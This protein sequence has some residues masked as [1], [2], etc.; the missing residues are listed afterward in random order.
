VMSSWKGWGEGLRASPVPSFAL[1]VEKVVW[2]YASPGWLYAPV[3]CPELPQWKVPTAA[4]DRWSSTKFS[5][6]PAGVLGRRLL[7]YGF[8]RADVRYCQLEIDHSLFR[9]RVGSR[10]RAPTPAYVAGAR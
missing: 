2:K 5:G 4:L 9:P 3:Y 7:A 1:F 6:V 10:S 8:A